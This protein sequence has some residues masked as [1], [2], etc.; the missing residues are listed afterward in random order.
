M[1]TEAIKNHTFAVHLRSAAVGVEPRP[2]GL[3]GRKNQSAGSRATPSFPQNRTVDGK[4]S[5]HTGQ[6][7][8][9]A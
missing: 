6:T 7:F 8:S 3:L 9:F 2:W 4:R 1:R 5:P